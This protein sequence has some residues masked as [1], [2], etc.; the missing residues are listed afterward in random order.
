M[1]NMPI[2]FPG[3]F[4]FLVSFSPVIFSFFFGLGLFPTTWVICSEVYPPR[5]K[6]FGC[7]L[8]VM[9]RIAGVIAQAKLYPGAML[10]MS[11][12]RRK[13]NIRTFRTLIA[14][15]CPDPANLFLLHGIFCLVSCV[16]LLSGILPETQGRTLYQLTQPPPLTVAATAAASASHPHLQIPL[17]QEEGSA[18]AVHIAAA[19]SKTGLQQLGMRQFQQQS[20]MESEAGGAAAAAAAGE[21]R[22]LCERM[23]TITVVAQSSTK[24]DSKWLQQQQEQLLQKQEQRKLREDEFSIEVATAAAAANQ[25]LRRKQQRKLQF[26]DSCL[27]QIPTEEVMF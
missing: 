23:G 5:A 7:A 13:K 20:S 8:A 24:D 2:F 27:Q 9:T 3:L 16:L 14:F 10:Y 6:E 17:Q 12:Y 21:D 26:D 19:E 18:A 22:R 4:G 1:L 25:Q 11:E 15:F